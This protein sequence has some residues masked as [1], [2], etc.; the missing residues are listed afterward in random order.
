M[1]RTRRRVGMVIVLLAS[2]SGSLFLVLQAF[3][4]NLMFFYT[5][6]DLSEQDLTGKPFRLG[7]IVKPKS[8]SR[9]QSITTFTIISDPLSSVSVI[10][11]Y[12]G[13]LPDLFRE[14]QGIIVQ[15]HLQ[16]NGTFKAKTVLAKHDEIYKPPSYSQE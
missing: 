14:G 7:G 11:T 9:H 3:Q 15:G 13:V 10:V 5:P 1:K 16:T 6:S 2:L 4:D 12:Q 8:V